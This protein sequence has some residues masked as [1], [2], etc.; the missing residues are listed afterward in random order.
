M[1]ERSAACGGQRGRARGSAR[2]MARW[3]WAATLLAAVQAWRPPHKP[4]LLSPS[5]LVRSRHAHPTIHHLH[6]F[7]WHLELQ[8][9]RAI[10]SPYYDECQF[11]KGR[12]LYEDESSVTVTECGGQLYGLLQVGGEEFVL[13][14]TR[15]DGRSSH[16]LR[17]RDVMLSDLPAAYN[18]TGD[19]VADLEFDFDDEPPLPHVR[20]RHSESDGV[21][22]YRN[23]RPVTRPLSGVILQFRVPIAHVTVN[24]MNFIVLVSGVK[25]LWLEMAIVADHTMLKFHGQERVK[26]YIL[27]L[28]NIVSMIANV[29]FLA[30]D[31]INR[32]FM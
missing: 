2:T 21:D 3:L 32:P 11:Y 23:V 7:G 1:R 27:A 5:A 28:M 12:V 15:P 17:R 18:L 20:P 29:L 14:P 10:R 31:P 26:H 9:N 25:G 6:L 16:V 19:T 30:L 22:Q 4:I 24:G 8:E 13:Q